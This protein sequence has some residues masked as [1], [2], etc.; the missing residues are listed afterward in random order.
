MKSECGTNWESKADISVANL[1]EW[2]PSYVMGHKKS[3]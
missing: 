3:A 1:S 2:E